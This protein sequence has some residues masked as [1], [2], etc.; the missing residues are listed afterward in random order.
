[1]KKIS[2]QEIERRIKTRFPEESFKIIEYNGLGNKGKVK[3]L[4]CNNIIE[5]N[6]F[7]NFFAKN[8]KYGCKQCN[9]LWR[10][11]ENKLNKIKEKYY[12]LNTE[13]IDTHT[14]YQIKCRKCG[15][16]RK[17]SLKNL[18][19]HLECGCQTKV[20]RNRTPEEFINECN[21]YYNN[22]LELVGQY[23]NQ[24]TKVLLRHKPC[25]MIW[26]V[27]PPDIIHGKSH[28]PKCRTQE[29]LGIK[30]IKKFLEEKNIYFIQEYQLP[31]SRQRL[32]FFLPN[33]NL[34]IE[35]NGKQHYEYIEFFHKNIEGFEKYKERDIK[36]QK[37]CKENNIEILDIS[38]K[39]D[40]NINQILQE[41]LNKF[42]D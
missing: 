35:Y 30:K 8:K 42:N 23:K 17:S 26:S 39:E 31:N 38:Y 14:Y 3:C 28:C 40:N 33:Y 9:G 12:I 15:H 37:I 2:I 21:L 5:V 20:F 6:K 1:M 25:G 4:Q 29:S 13:N 18:Y 36:K 16:I 11:R 19:T 27:N 22:E 34:G 32:D 7:N 10:E 24:T 41:K